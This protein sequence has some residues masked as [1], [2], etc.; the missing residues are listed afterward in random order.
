MPQHYTAFRRTIHVDPS[1]PVH[2]NVIRT[3]INNIRTETILK[4]LSQTDFTGINGG[5]FTG[6]SY[7]QPP[8]EGRSIAFHIEDAGK[9]TP[10]STSVYRNWN[11]NGSSTDYKR[12]KTLILRNNNGTILPHY[13][14]VAKANDVL[15]QY[16]NVRQIIG[17]RDYNP[18]NWGSD[19]YSLPLPRTILAW[20]AT[21]AYLMV[22]TGV[23]IPDLKKTMELM[24]SGITPI[25]SIVLDGSGSSCM[26]VTSD[27][28]FNL[29]GGNRYLFNCIRLARNF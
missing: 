25:N 27:S 4:P 13:Q 18:E 5:F 7:N 15:N 6:P 8:T 19:S 28:D 11:Y 24:G 29:R 22:S 1:F 12:Q 9:L 14:Y 23:S 17:G 26:Q 21:Q 10:G 20:T 2:F 3:G 16:D